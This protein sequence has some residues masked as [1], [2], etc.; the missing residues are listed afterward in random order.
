MYKGELNPR[1]VQKA[2]KELVDHGIDCVA[3]VLWTCRAGADLEE[4]KWFCELHNLPIKYFNENHP[5]ALSWFSAR[6]N[7][8]PRKIF[9][10]EYW[11]DRAVEVR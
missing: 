11:D 3:F 4:A 7:G 6:G 5:L 9:G 10:H 2:R 1:W 8:E